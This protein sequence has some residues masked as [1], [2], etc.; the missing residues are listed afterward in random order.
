MD[1]QIPTPCGPRFA[2]AR[3]R[4]NAD[5]AKVQSAMLAC[6]R[7]A[8]THAAKSV[9][10][11]PLAVRIHEGLVWSNRDKRTLLDKMLGLLDILAIEA[12]F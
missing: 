12:P 3:F 10:S 9:F 5:A 4:P 11:V 1:L 7:T 6:A 2:E 8:S